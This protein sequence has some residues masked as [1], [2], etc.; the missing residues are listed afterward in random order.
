MKIEVSHKKRVGK[1]SNIWRLKNIL[2]K[3]EWVNQEI[4]EELKS[5]WKQMKMKA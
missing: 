1:T 4:K 5:T 2:L 3:N